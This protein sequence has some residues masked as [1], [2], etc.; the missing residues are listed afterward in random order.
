MKALVVAAIYLLPFIAIGWIAKRVIDRR[1]RGTNLI[2]VHDLAGP[3]RR[4]RKVFLLG[5]WREEG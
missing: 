4:K 2:D 3:N 1:M 5:S